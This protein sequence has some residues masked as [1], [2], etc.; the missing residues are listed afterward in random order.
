M[1]RRPAPS[2]P[3]ASGS[4]AKDWTTR[5]HRLR[6]AVAAAQGS[7]EVLGARLGQEFERLQAHRTQ[8]L[9]LLSNELVGGI[10]SQPQAAARLERFDVA[11]RVLP[12]MGALQSSRPGTLAQKLI[13]AHEKLLAALNDPSNTSREALQA[14]Q[15]FA[16]EA[17]ALQSAFTTHP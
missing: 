11:V 7:V 14:L 1:P 8:I 2:S 12:A 10:S 13:S 3:S 15:E 9:D 4:S 16:A 6:Q 5:L 17:A